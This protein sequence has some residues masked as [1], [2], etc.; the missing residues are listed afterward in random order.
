MLEL[1]QITKSFPG[2]FEPVLNGISLRLAVGEFCVV[3]GA[4][5]S[6]KSTLL[7]IISG[8]YLADS[9][10][11]TRQ[12][13]VCEVGQDVNKGTVSSLTL[14]EN[15]ALSQIR[16]EKP[17]FAFYN[18]FKQDI[19]KEI[20]KIG[21]GLEKLINQP[22]S[23]LSG[24]QRQIIATL[25]AF[26]SGGQI[27]ALDEH[28]SA[29]DPKM[30]IMLMEYSV[31]SIMEQNLTTLMI[32]HKMDDAIKYGNRLIM[33]NKGKIVVDIK[34]SEKSKLK[35]QDLLEMFHK[36]EDQVLLPGGTK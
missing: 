6:G 31:K 10:E 20:K 4:N 18:R 3:I 1:K 35:T 30:Q 22:I 27:L 29:L 25:M 16:K 9:G 13:A 23:S 12:G 7:K 8:E 15:V 28:T 14:L 11:I 33:L 2:I 17:K 21:I 24:G 5:G 19:I 34:E 26:N 32:T 36:Y